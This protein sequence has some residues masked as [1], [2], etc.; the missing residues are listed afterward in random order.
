M[1]L[2][3]IIQ[4][5]ADTL[6]QHDA[7]AIVVGGSVRDH[8][9]GVPIKDYDVE[10]YGLET[11]EQLEGILAVF[12]S[13]NL[14][15]KSFGVLKFMYEGDEYDF[16]LPRIEEKTGEGHRG[17]TVSVDGTLSFA[18][19]ARRR[20]FT[21]NALGYD[22]HSQT[23]LD[24][25]G[26]RED[27]GKR[28]L[29][30][31]DTKTFVEDP[32]R[33][34][35][36]VQF[37]ARFGYTLADK[38]KTLC[39]KMVDDRML[40][41]LPK[42]RIYIEWMKLL[43]KSTKPSVGFEMMRE[44]GIL[45]YFPEL[46][47][48]IGVPQDAIYHPEGDVWVHT[49]LCVDAMANLVIAMEDEK[50]KLKYFFAILC[51][52]LGKATT[53]TFEADGQIRAIG[54]EDTGIAL[55]RSLLYR[56]TNE[57]D[58]IESIVPLVEHHLK[59]SQFYKAQSTDKAIRRLSTKVNIEEL[60]IVAKADFMGRTTSEALSGMYKAGEWLL[61][62]ARELKVEKKPLDPLLQGRDL[63]ALGLL[64]S[65]KFKEILDAV[66]EAQI[67]GKINDKEE[68]LAFVKEELMKNI[69]N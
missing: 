26:G 18:N 21:V 65:P 52:D 24:P 30:H 59:P 9:L 20:D 1:K 61:D 43:L 42:E 34:Y 60:V 29:R 36:A 66:Y 47:A 49:M 41:S 28:V 15:G 56:L 50:Q 37:A 44:L 10:V 38:T 31:I 4:T 46:Y 63:I 58:F 13:V 48:L 69:S 27:M 23:F 67:E 5:I 2:P 39:Q 25:F 40:A 22:I 6:Y 45:H 53:T 57:H 68:A 8:F 54:H 7:R 12:G 55:T 51:H 19:A 16:S 11:I 62:R 35:R 32:L 17:F 14:V 3:T 33:V 64:P